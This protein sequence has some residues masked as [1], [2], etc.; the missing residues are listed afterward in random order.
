MKKELILDVNEFEA[1]L[2]LLED[3]ELSEIRIEYFGQER[4]IGNIYKGRVENILPGMSAAFVDVGLSRNAFLYAGDILPE[5]SDFEFRGDDG[6]LPAPNISEMLKCGQEIVVQVLKQQGGTKGVRVTTQVSLPGRSTVLMPTIDHIGVSKR[7][8]DE[9]ERERLRD[10]IARIKPE[11][12]GVIVRTAAERC[13]EEEL[14]RELELLQKLWFQIEKKAQLLCAPRLIHAEENLIFRVVRDNL[15]AD[16][17][18]LT[19]NDKASFEKISAAVEITAPEFSDK[20][21]LYEHGGNI[22]DLYNIEHKIERTLSRKVWLKSGGYLIIDETE[23]LTVIDVNTGK[24]TGTD[25]LQKTLLSANIEAAREI[26]RQLRLR[27]IGGIV[28]IDFID[29]E[30]DEFRAAVVE[31]L[32]TA[33]EA[34]KTKTNVLGFTALGLVELTRKKM[35]RRISEITQ[36]SCQKCGGSGKVDSILTLAMKLR[37]EVTRTLHGPGEYLIEASPAL[38]DFIVEKNEDGKNLLPKV[39]GVTYF[40]KTDEGMSDFKVSVMKKG[41]GVLKVF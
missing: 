36:K 6:K 19:I 11:K 29:M 5:K 27:D 28:V 32:T 14:A 23:A 2:A 18:S 15:G 9:G 33:L 40:L 10:V 8:S 16:I 25:D 17:E 7:I 1:R 4:L 13:S 41:G 30:S 3:G 21:R 20:I 39:D 24:F 37:R 35:R 26:A 31:A 38:C 22:F 12:M 34:D